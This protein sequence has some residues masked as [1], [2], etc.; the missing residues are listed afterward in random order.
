MPIAPPNSPLL[1]PNVY[2]STQTGDMGETVSR[3][4]MME[5][6]GEQEARLLGTFFIQAIFLALVSHAVLSMGVESI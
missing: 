2:P 5:I 3:E 4:D 6:K 1:R